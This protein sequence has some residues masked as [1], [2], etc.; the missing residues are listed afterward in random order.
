MER[1]FRCFEPVDYYWFPGSVRR[2]YVL[3]S[4]G[5]AGDA[6]SGVTS[7]GRVFVISVTD[8][9]SVL[10]DLEGLY[11]QPSPIIEHQLRLSGD[12]LDVPIVHE[13]I[14]GDNL[15]QVDTYIVREWLLE[16]YHGVQVMM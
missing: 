12:E 1:T 10:I 4:N 14:G 3:S 7:K 8:A 15:T 16:G 6:L 9:C 13:P 5:Q 2:G 11:R